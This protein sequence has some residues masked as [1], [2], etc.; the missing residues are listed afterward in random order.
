[1]KVT[2]TFNSGYTMDVSVAALD[3]QLALVCYQDTSA[4]NKVGTR[5]GAPLFFA[6]L[7]H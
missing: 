5:R 4:T 3:E 2:E 6:C 1:M 7:S